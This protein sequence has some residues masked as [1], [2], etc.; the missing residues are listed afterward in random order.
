MK[1]IPFTLFMTLLSALLLQGCGSKV[2][3]SYPSREATSIRK[4]TSSS[5]MQDRNRIPPT[6]RPYVIYGKTYYPIPSA[7]GYEERGVAS[8]YGPKFHGRKTSNGETYD[9]YGMTAAHKILPMNTQVLVRNLDCGK[10]VVLR[11]NDRGPFA[12]DRI[13]DLSFGAAKA[14][15]VDGPGTARVQVTA[16]GEAEQPMPGDHGQRR[17]RP[18]QNF[19][20]GEFFVQI[21]AFTNK[22]NA[23]RLTESMNGRGSKTISQVYNHEDGN[24]YYR[25]QV[26][27][28]NTLEEAK[29]AERDWERLYP[30][31]FV[32]AR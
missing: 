23:D 32:L 30:G 3:R 12:K 6:Q 8:W 28:G 13:I 31:A 20:E 25:V 1:K 17:F 22:E 15:G 18:Y 2:F 9:M 7:Y 24:R 10:E 5:Q 29:K 26:K 21:G 27:A 4:P 11:V 16:L 14:L 19:N